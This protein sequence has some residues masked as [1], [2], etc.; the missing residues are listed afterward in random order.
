MKSF[1]AFTK[2]EWLENFRTNRIY[3]LGIVFLLLGIMNPVVAFMTPELIGSMDLG[4]IVI[5]L[6]D[7][8]ALDSWIQFFGNISIIGMLALIVSYCGIMA[9]EISRGTLVNLLTKGM[10]RHVVILSKFFSATTLWT[11]VYLLC[12]GVTHAY[13]SFYW[14]GDEFTLNHGFVAFLAPWLFGVL[15]L[16]LLIFGG[17]LTG[18]F[19]G[20]LLT[21]GGV[22]VVLNLINL[23]PNV[24]RFN[25]ITL[26]SGTLALLDNSLEVSDF[27]PAIMVCLVAIVVLLLGSI[28]VFNKRRI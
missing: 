25:P 14:S 11:G 1:V 4:G 8:T 13:T 24:A 10:K 18:T 26:A 16:A 21:G 22:V 12:L 17:I 20:S 15:L 6:P 2:K 28:G 9:N 5:D 3:I 7:P 23:I 27:V 19:P